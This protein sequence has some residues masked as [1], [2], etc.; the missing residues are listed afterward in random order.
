MHDWLYKMASV[1]NTAQLFIANHRGEQR[2]LLNGDL[3]Y[4]RKEMLLFLTYKCYKQPAE[5]RV[6]TR[7]R[8][9]FA[10]REE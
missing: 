6:L 7:L 4:V 1:R 3:I 5:P 2:Q 8:E 10:K 9:V